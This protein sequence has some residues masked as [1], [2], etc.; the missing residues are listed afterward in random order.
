MPNPL[1]VKTSP[2]AQ[3]FKIGQPDGK[4]LAALFIF[5]HLAG[6][7]DFGHHPFALDAVPEYRY[8]WA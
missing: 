1:G 8:A 3:G 6:F 7:A 2:A 4:Q 5:L